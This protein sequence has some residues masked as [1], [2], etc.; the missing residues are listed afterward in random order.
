[1]VQITG[2]RLLAVPLLCILVC[3]VSCART[4]SQPP[5]SVPATAVEST[6]EQ[7]QV[8]LTVELPV[9][10]DPASWDWKGAE[11][12]TKALRGTGQFAVNS[13]ADTTWPRY[14]EGLYTDAV[15][16]P[17]LAELP[18]DEPLAELS[19]SQLIRKL[20]QDLNT[21]GYE[22]GTPDGKLGP[23]TKSAIERFVHDNSPAGP[24]SSQ[25]KPSPRASE[26]S[27]EWGY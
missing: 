20:Q 13:I 17:L 7:P 1:M 27:S 25:E 10:Q 19:P 4:V 5:P 8:R 21:L 2:P 16:S 26:R 3:L 22:C 24:K 14:Q 6:S 9:S 11:E 23:K 15:S 12:L 18:P